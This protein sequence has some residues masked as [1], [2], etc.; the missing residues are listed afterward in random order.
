M[1]NDDIEVFGCLLVCTIL[2]VWFNM[3]LHCLLVLIPFVAVIVFDVVLLLAWPAVPFMLHFLVT[4]VLR[5]LFWLVS[6]HAALAFVIR[7]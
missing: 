2:F 4:C 6:C 1:E 7:W 5:L 3:I